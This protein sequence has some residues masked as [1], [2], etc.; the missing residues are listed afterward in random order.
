MMK[1]VS[2]AIVAFACASFACVAPAAAATLHPG[3]KIDVQVFYHPELSSTVVV[4]SDGSIELPVAGVIASGGL[5]TSE[6]AHRIAAR[7]SHYVIDPTVRVSIETQGD[8]IFVAGGPSGVLH[9]Q[10]GETLVSITDQLQYTPTQRPERL[11]LNAYDVQQKPDQGSAA[12]LDI[13]NGPIDFKRVSV[14]RD[15]KSI[16]PFDLIALRDAGQPGIALNP[17]DTVQLVNKPVVVYVHGEVAQ[18]GPVYLYPTDSLHRAVDQAGGTTTTAS[19]TKITLVRN[20][21]P[22]VLS[23]GNPAFSAPAQ[24]GDQVFVPR[25]PRIDVLG[26]VVHPGETYLRGNQ[27]LVSAIYYAGGPDRFANLK[28]VQVFHD[29]VKT[30]YNLAHLQK[31]HEGDNPPLVDGDTVFVPQGSTIDASLI[32]QAIGTLGFLI[33]R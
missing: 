2:A 28:A 10:P 4:N 13:F 16:G 19:Q 32:F 31:G 3:D 24:S 9:Y 5:E 25:A 26:T 17:G 6:V 23:L 27:T 1:T 21:V 30:E 18:P 7:L 12:P 14:L 22:E 8:S 29:G 20:A 15:G 33:Y 11:D